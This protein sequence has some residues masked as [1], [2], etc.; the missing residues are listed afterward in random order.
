MIEYQDRFAVQAEVA[1]LPFLLLTL[2]FIFF[3]VSLLFS[4]RIQVY[5]WPIYRGKSLPDPPT[6]PHS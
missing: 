3:H 5:I 1:R 2:R 4:I 6:T